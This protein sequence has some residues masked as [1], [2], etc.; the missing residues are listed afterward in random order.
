ML[1]S[2]L[3]LKKSLFKQTIPTAEHKRQKSRNTWAQNE[4]EK[5]Y[6]RKHLV[7]PQKRHNVEA[8]SNNNNN[9]GN[10]RSEEKE[11]KIIKSFFQSKDCNKKGAKKTR[12][13]DMQ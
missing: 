9:A 6:T 1:V 3:V 4:D 13:R 10:K 2:Q 8:P 11:E 12:M 7:P 5:L